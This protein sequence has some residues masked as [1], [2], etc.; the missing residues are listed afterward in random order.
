[1]HL[2]KGDSRGEVTCYKVTQPV[3]GKAGM[4]AHEVPQPVLLGQSQA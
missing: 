4:N 2:Q 1:M 3:N